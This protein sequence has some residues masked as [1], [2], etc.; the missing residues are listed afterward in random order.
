MKKSKSAESKAKWP[1]RLRT[2]KLANGNQSLYLDCYLNGERHCETLFHL[3]P[4]TSAAAKAQNEEAWRLAKAIQSQRVLEIMS[5]K[6]GISKADTRGKMLLLDWLECCRER[7]EKA[8]K[9]SVSDS[10]AGVIYQLRLYGADK[11]MIKDVSR[12]SILKFIEYLKNTES[13]RGGKLKQATQHH[14][15]SLLSEAL[16]MAV[17]EGIIRS[18]PAL[19]LDTDERPKKQQSMREYLTIDEVKR[20]TKTDCRNENVKRAFMF[21]C[22]CGLRVSDIR[23]LKWGD[24][25]S[26]GGHYKIRQVTKKTKKLDYVPLSDEAMKWLPQRQ[27]A[28]DGDNVYS[29]ISQNLVNKRLREWASLAGINKHVSFHVSRHT[30]ATTLLTLGADLYTT[31][32]LLGHSNVATTTIYAKIVDAKKAEAVNLVNDIFNKSEI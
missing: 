14:I 24:I 8:G 16:S 13:K 26:D 23:A 7:K 17:K 27:G 6:A 22:F 21:S 12:S 2:R 32:K 11:V 30:F 3:I 15:F 5:G 1:V 18:N 9:K 20:L 25:I 31:S 19:E 29:L 28:G 10:M 4:E